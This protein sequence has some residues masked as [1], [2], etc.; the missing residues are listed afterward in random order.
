MKAIKTL[1]IGIALC[2]FLFPLLVNAEF[3]SEFNPEDEPA[4]WVSEYY[5]AEGVS[6]DVGEDTVS[7]DEVWL[8]YAVSDS[9]E[10]YIVKEAPDT[11]A[12]S[13]IHRVGFLRIPDKDTGKWIPI[14]VRSAGIRVSGEVWVFIRNLE[15]TR[16]PGI[17]LSG[18]DELPYNSYADIYHTGWIPGR[19][20]LGVGIVINEPTG[21]EEDQPTLVLPKTSL[22]QNYPNPFNPTTTISF[23]LGGPPESIQHV[24]LNVYDIRGRYVRTVIDTDL[25]P[26]THRVV[27]DGRNGKGEQVLSGTYFYTLRSE[28]KSITRKLSIL[29]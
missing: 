17:D 22:S 20:N 8:H 15:L 1:I 29:K 28:G 9:I 7:L 26:G 12:G 6:F 19:A 21:I 27:W 24:T 5:L 11:T 18:F 23:D 3:L 4:Y 2:V 25:V 13:L 16:P 14:D 10:L